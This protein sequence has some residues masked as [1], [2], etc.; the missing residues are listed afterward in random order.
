MR[1]TYLMIKYSII[2]FYLN[3]LAFYK[4]RN[5]NKLNHKLIKAKHYKKIINT[6]H[7]LIY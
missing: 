3:N 6:K 1:L 7:K 5:N 2:N 4:N